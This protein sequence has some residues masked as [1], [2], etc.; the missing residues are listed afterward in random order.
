MASLNSPEMDQNVLR[1]VHEVLRRAR[2]HLLILEDILSKTR[3]GIISVD[4]RVHDGQVVDIII[5]DT[6]RIKL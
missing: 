3:N 6:H 1:Y 2:P 5:K 4:M